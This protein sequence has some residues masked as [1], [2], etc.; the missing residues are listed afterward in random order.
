MS[1]TIS[2][3]K[4]TKPKP[5]TEFTVFNKLPTELRLK[6]WN[7]AASARM[8]N[9]PSC[10]K[11]RTP[12]TFGVLQACRESRNELRHRYTHFYSLSSQDSFSAGDGAQI[13]RDGL[14]VRT[15]PVFIDFETD[16]FSWEQS[17]LN[18]EVEIGLDG[19]RER[20]Y[21]CTFPELPHSD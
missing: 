2:V 11:L 5:L 10:V 9:L 16:V 12:Q 18:L 3:Q 6:I 1:P 4:P 13:S 8:V 19:R 20:S 21:E 14:R 7:L 17:L 15:D